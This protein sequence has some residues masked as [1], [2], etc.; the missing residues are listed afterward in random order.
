MLMELKPSSLHIDK[1]RMSVYSFMRNTTI[2]Q[3][4]KYFLASSEKYKGSK[5]IR[6][7]PGVQG[8][9]TKAVGRA[10]GLEQLNE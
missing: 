2:K 10:L 7:L 9:R 4:R 1:T 3:I 8:I 6:Q 5:I